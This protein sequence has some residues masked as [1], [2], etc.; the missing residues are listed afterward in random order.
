MMSGFTAIEMVGATESKVADWNKYQ[1]DADENGQ[2]WKPDSIF[3][4]ARK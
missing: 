2:P 1:L 3:V 4:E